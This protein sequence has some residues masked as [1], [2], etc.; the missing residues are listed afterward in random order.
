MG[1]KNNKIDEL[2]AKHLFDKLTDEE[3]KLLQKSVEDNPSV[4]KILERSKGLSDLLED[5]DS[6]LNPNEDLAWNNLVEKIEAGEGNQKKGIVKELPVL[7]YVKKSYFIRVAAVVFVLFG[8]YFSF[9]YISD[10]S[11]ESIESTYLLSEQVSDRRVELSTADGVDAVYLPDNSLVYLNDNT[12]LVYD[13]GF[14]LG[15]RTVYLEGEA[16]FKVSHNPEKP[17]IVYTR[18][19]KTEVLG[20]S[21]NVK[22]H[23]GKD[24][25]EVTVYS[26]KVG[27]TKVGG[28]ESDTKFLLKDDVASLNHKSGLVSMGIMIDNESI[29]W[30]EDY[31]TIDPLKADEQI[32]HADNDIEI[33]LPVDPRIAAMNAELKNPAR[34]LSNV[35]KWENLVMWDGRLKKVTDI[36]GEIYNSAVF[37]KYSKIELSATLYDE[38]N[39]L[40]G[41]EVFEIDDVVEAGKL[42]K[43]KYELKA[44]HDG[45]NRVVVEVVSAKGEKYLNK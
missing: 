12:N 27:F 13:E 3:E 44:W 37:V 2:I 18:T 32:T 33:E 4:E 19:A 11:V 35:T 45:L 1:E 24:Y 6:N 15:K 14:S 7:N 9:K 28:T 42:A 41:K 21:F 30:V 31:K 39:N 20:T 43:Y 5:F 36:T 25:T 10:G 38:E 22:A 40:L 26:G 16:F 17:F 8:F 29:Q 23:T 34:Y